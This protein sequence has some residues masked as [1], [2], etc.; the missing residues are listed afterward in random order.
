MKVLKYV[1]Y[2]FLF[3][4]YIFLIILL[5]LSGHLDEEGNPR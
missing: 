4:V 5:E 1:K 3:A 2:F